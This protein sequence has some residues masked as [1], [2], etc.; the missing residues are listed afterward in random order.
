MSDRTLAGARLHLRP[1]RAADVSDSYVGWLNDPLVNRF[2]ESRF[3]PQT[4]E[5][6]K[7]FVERAEADAA[8]H[9]YAIV[10]SEGRHIGNIKLGP[11]DAPHERGDIGIMIGDRTCWGMGYATEAIAMLTE[12]AFADLRLHKVTAGAYASNAG[13]IKAFER[14]G[15]AVEAVRRAH[16]RDDGAWTDAVLLARF[17]ER[18]DG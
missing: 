14:A 12:W 4:T 17:A 10:L 1:L 3:Q 11:I 13:S 18:H 8:T 16:Y 15:Y 7:A 9:L 2:L 5:T 6:V